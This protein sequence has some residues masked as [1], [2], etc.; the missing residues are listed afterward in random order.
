L[1]M[2]LGVKAM[3]GDSLCSKA[4]GGGVGAVAVAVA[5]VVVIG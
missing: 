3:F 1:R 5:V 2:S 4:V